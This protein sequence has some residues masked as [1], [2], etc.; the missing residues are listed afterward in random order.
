MYT[1]ALGLVE[2]QGWVGAVEALD[3]MTKTAE[4][5]WLDTRDVGA[6]RYCVMVRG[7]VGAVKA[8]TDAGAAAAH[9]VGELLGVHVI[10]RPDDQLRRLIPGLDRGPEAYRG[11]PDPRA[12]GASIEDMGVVELRRHARTLPGLAIQG[13]EISMANREVLLR[14]IRRS[15]G[16]GTS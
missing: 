3:A 14:E 12:G 16:E 8:A 2:T 6:G 10:P 15:R 4:V 11:G 9:R 5:G 13:R 1:N 7:A